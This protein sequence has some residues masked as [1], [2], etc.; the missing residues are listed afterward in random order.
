MH[1]LDEW[2]TELRRRL[3]D[4]ERLSNR[5]DDPI[6]Y[7]VFPPKHMLY[8]KRK[9]VV[10]KSQLHK[11]DGWNVHVL[12][13]ADKLNS[14]FFEHPNRQD[15]LAYSKEHPDDFATVFEDQTDVLMQENPIKKWIIDGMKKASQE[16]RGLF[17]LTDLEAI[18]PYLRIGT[19]E[20]QLQGK[21]LVPLVILYPGVRSGRSAL[22]FLGVYPPDGN[23]RSVHI[24]GSL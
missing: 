23:Y 2:F 24:G 7:F 14:F 16:S 10:W 4:T 1:T 8:V 17:M 12:S 22:R 19:V 18:H 15:W 6:Y 9:L 5:G 3:K 11:K 13:L 20:Q 21:C